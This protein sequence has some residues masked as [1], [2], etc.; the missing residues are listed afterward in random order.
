MSFIGPRKLVAEDD[1]N[2][3]SVNGALESAAEDHR[4]LGAQPFLLPGHALRSSLQFQEAEDRVHADL[5][6]WGP[7]LF[8]K[9][10]SRV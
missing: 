4:S 9:V 8:L 1:E 5:H 10:S 3:R 6:E 2:L 7:V